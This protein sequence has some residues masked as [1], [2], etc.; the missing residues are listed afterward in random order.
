MSQPL[1]LTNGVIRTM[2]RVIPRVEA[3]AIEG[4][5]ILGMG[6]LA[7]MPDGKRVDLGGRLV[8]PGLTDAHLHILSFALAQEQIPLDGVPTLD[9]ALANVAARAAQTPAGEWLVGWGWNH[10]L[11]PTGLPTRADL[12][13]VAPAHPVLLTR[14]DG[15]GV[16]ANSLAL[17]LAGVTRDTPDPEGGAILRD[18]EGEPTGILAEDAMS[19][20]R[21]IIPEPNAERRRAA[22]GRAWP[23]FHK[24]GLVG[25]HEMGWNDP[26][27]LWADFEA[28]KAEGQ[29]PWRITHYIHRHQ[30]N[31]LCEREMR[32]GQGDHFL[33]LGGVKIFMDGALGPQ[34]ADMLDDY[35]GQPGNRGIVTTE[36]DE[37]RDILTFGTPAGLSVAIHAIGDAAN[38]KVLDCFT[39]WRNG[40]GANSPLRQRIE[41]VQVLHPDDVT[42]LAQLDVVAS[43]QPIHA[44]SDI[45]IAEKYWG[46]RAEY[47]YAYCSLLSCGTKMAFGS[48]APVESPDPLA[49]IHAAVTRQRANGYP[50]GGWYPQQRLSVWDAVHGY[51]LGAAYASGEESIKGSLLPGK[52]A[53]LVV[54]DRDIFA[55]DPAEILQ[56]HVVGTMLGGEWVYREEM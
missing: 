44:T 11:W 19:L 4:D 34:T 56:T 39:E 20:V 16:W 14:K 43:V 46:K 41:H 2:D 15:H 8:L 7:D 51:T 10:N 29:L 52:L 35:E 45:D 37:L 42:R 33:R 6:R 40:V 24:L 32:S 36:P 49:G 31:D 53:D 17:G 9:A 25:G 26:L 23:L 3:I 18:D 27:A 22:L 28:L 48:D 38:R 55:I 30:F 5:R 50:P 21:R 47:G 1:V 13:R 12:D 54:L